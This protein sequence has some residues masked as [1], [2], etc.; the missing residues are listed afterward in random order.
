MPSSLDITELHEPG[1]AHAENKHLFDTSEALASDDDVTSTSK[2][3]ES[4]E[5]ENVQ[6]LEEDETSSGPPRPGHL[7]KKTISIGLG[8]ASTVFVINLAVFIWALT[9]SKTIQGS[10][11]FYEGSCTTSRHISFAISLLINLLSTLLLAASNNAGQ[12]ISSPTRAEIDMAHDSGQWLYIGSFSF[13]NLRYIGW[14]RIIL[15][16]GFMCTSFPLHLL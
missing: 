8:I 3:E 16:L 2:P 13:R 7:L 15:W 1:S 14:K 5:D 10:S 11:T 4:T 9:R 6:L 12:Y